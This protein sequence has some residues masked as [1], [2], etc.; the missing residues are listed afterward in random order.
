MTKETACAYMAGGFVVEKTKCMVT[1]HVKG[2]LLNTTQVESLS[3]AEGRTP[4]DVV[5]DL[6]VAFDVALEDLDV[7]VYALHGEVRGRDLD[8]Q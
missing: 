5:G 6:A 3:P 7:S 4:V 1:L 8:K 2:E